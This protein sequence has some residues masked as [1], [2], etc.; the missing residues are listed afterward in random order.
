M[1]ARPLLD[2]HETPPI[3]H[4]SIRRPVLGLLTMPPKVVKADPLLAA[5]AEAQD[6]YTAAL[7]AAGASEAAFLERQAE[8]HA[9]VAARASALRSATDP[10]SVPP[11]PDPDAAEAALAVLLSEHTRDHREASRLALVVDRAHAA[12]R[13]PL[14]AL[15]LEGVPGLQETAEA[16]IGQAEAAYGA[17]RGALLLVEEIDRHAV[18]VRFGPSLPGPVNDAILNAYRPR[19]HEATFR[20]GVDGKVA[21]VRE[22]GLAFAE[23]RHLTGAGLDRILPDPLGGVL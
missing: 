22:P 18:A 14:R 8:Y 23:V 10:A 4:A 3:L 7:D 1:T 11:S 15:A 19:R 21:P 20:T 13:G 9:A 2:P 6:N 5:V 16:A 12:A 17:L